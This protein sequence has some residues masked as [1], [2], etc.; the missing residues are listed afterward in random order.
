[1]TAA[2]RGQGLEIQMTKIEKV[3]SF[4]ENK[5]GTFSDPHKLAAAAEEKFDVGIYV[6]AATPDRSHLPGAEGRKQRSMHAF[7][8]YFKR[9]GAWSREAGWVYLRAS[10]LAS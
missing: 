10:A 2:P 1:M 8:V 9:S 7:Q 4:I 3:G 6:D 5:A